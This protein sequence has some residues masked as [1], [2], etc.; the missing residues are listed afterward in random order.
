[1]W[2]T[3]NILMCYAFINLIQKHHLYKKKRS[4]K[5]IAVFSYTEQSRCQIAHSRKK[6]QT[7]SPSFPD[8][9][10]LGYSFLLYFLLTGVVLTR[11]LP[12]RN[13]YLWAVLNSP[14]AF[15]W[16]CYP[17][18]LVVGRAFPQKEKCSPMYSMLEAHLK[19]PKGCILFFQMPCS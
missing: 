7:P 12:L 2:F 8:L 5:I 11:Y 6:E 15:C 4:N 16:F 9:W 17:F 14:R 3:F 10:H 18:L 19:C 13:L 1:M